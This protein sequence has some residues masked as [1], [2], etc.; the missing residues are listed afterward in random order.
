MKNL[1]RKMSI[2]VL[3]AV[4]ILAQLPVY[5]PYG[6][7][8]AEEPSGPVP[9][10]V[11]QYMYDA[12]GADDGKEYILIKNYSET[13]V[14]LS[15]Y[16]IGD[17]IHQ[18]GGEGMAAFPE[19]TAVMPGQE[20]VIAQ[21]GLIFK[22]TYGVVP[23]FE[24]PW[25]GVFRPEDDP[26]VP[27][28]LNTDWSK[29]A[30]Q[31]ANGGDEILILN[32]SDEIV[33]FVPYIVDR[34]YRGVDY[35]AVDAT[36]PGNGN[37]IHRV[38]SSGDLTQDFAA[39]PPALPD[40]KVAV[41]TSTTLLITEVMYDPLFDETTGEYVEITNISGNPID[42]SGYYLGDEETEGQA[43]PEGMYNFPGGTVIAP[44]EAMIIARNAKGIEERHGVKAAFELEDSDPAVPEMVPS[45]SWGC[46]LMQLANT[47]DEVLLLDRNK[48]VVD[49]VVYR[50]GMYLGIPAHPGVGGGVSIERTSGADTKNSGFDFA[51]QPNPTPGLL[52]FGPQG[53]PDLIPVPDFKEHVLQLN[54]PSTMLAAVPTVIDASAGMPSELPS[55]IPS[56]LMTIGLTEGRLMALNRGEQLAAVL[57]RIAG[58]MLP[59]LELNDQEL[60]A[61]VHELLQL[62][63]MD[64]VVFISKHPQIVK[65][66]REWND[67]Y[68]GV[69][70]VEGAG[71]LSREKLEKIVLSV[72]RSTGLAVLID[73][74]ALT[75][76][77][78]RYLT[79]RGITVW[80]Y[81][82]SMKEEEIHSIVSLGISGIETEDTASVKSA[83]GRYDA[84]NSIGVP[85]LF[86]AHRGMSALA[87]ENTLPAFELSIRM[88]ADVI[89]T[90]ILQTKDG[91]LVVVH[92]FSVDRTTDGTGK[93]SELTLEELKRLTANKTDNEAWKPVYGEY[94]DARIPTLAELLALAKGTNVVLALEMKSIGYE[95][96]L[97]ELIEQYGM[98]T[99]VYV[100]SFSSEVLKRIRELNPDIGLGY[101]LNGGRPAQ[102]TEL[103]QAEK[104]VTDNVQL[105][106][107]FFGNSSLITPEFTR[108]AKHRGV[109]VAAW[110]VN[111]KQ[112]MQELMEQGVTGIVTDYAHWMADVPFAVHP[113]TISLKL[114]PG[115]VLSAFQLA[116]A[117]SRA[118]HTIPLSGGIRLLS[119]EEG[120]ISVEDSGQKLTALKKGTVTV[121]AYHD[122][123]PFNRS[124]D[125]DPM[126]LE[127]VWRVYSAPIVVQVIGGQ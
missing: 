62:K 97:V 31:L 91:E 105:G 94:P 65:Q 12:P 104:I 36:A 33:D 106:T 54:E 5:I 108:Y 44:Y 45:C 51:E 17:G 125:G 110:T 102:G 114:K 38:S 107:I 20:I 27:D 92:D 57:D 100:T 99:D 116:A 47:G 23:D 8:H 85:P 93:V 42:I 79:A 90:D 32:P 86:I 13:A 103:V 121:Q 78:V 40:R 19:G 21:S 124:A 68:R 71:E 74:R 113:F 18:G 50:A 29:G 118:S 123:R 2:S 87:P 81:G 37:A 60:L 6:T 22:Q 70:R 76:D 95:K 126:Q 49:A 64:D 122:I 84:A 82:S 10:K 115:D 69:L 75:R 16:K 61:P 30:V 112:G 46:G 34:T 72:R 52:L 80:A 120:V 101:I 73:H 4:T 28:M 77:N 96:K 25:I 119:G 63:G 26:D 111:T 14:D 56:F 67:E 41:P 15:G 3:L 89:E 1:V 88:K 39:A 59:V 9:V 98:V 55:D 35:K 53:R 7:V 83:L 109:P 11:L 117:A 24:F 58:G 66:L 127:D 43:S 48:K